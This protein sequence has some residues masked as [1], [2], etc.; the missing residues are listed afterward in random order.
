[1][2]QAIDKKK[3][4][5]NGRWRYVLLG[6]A[7]M[8]VYGTVYSWSIFRIPVEESYGVGTTLSG[9]PY[10]VFLATYAGS[11]MAGGKAIGR[12]SPR[13]ILLAGG[14]LV[15]LGWILSSLSTGIAMLTLTYGLLIGFGVG[16]SY[17]VPIYVITQWFPD[18]RGMTVG[19]VLA[20]FGLSPLFTAPLGSR[21]I[22]AF[23]LERTFLYY[24]LLFGV[25]IFLLAWP[26]KLPAQGASAS[27]TAEG[28]KQEAVPMVRQSS[29]RFAYACFVIGTLIGLAIIG[30][31]NTAGRDLVGLDTGTVAMMMVAFALFNGLGRPLF[32]WITETFGPAAAM[33]ISYGLIGTASLALL[34]AG[35]GT[36]VLY[37]AGFAILWMN[38]GAWL[39]IAPM[40]TMK[41]YGMAAYS[42]NYGIMFTAYG[43]GAVVGVIATG[44]ML[45]LFG[46]YRLL[47]LFMALLAAAG[48]FLSSRVES[49]QPEEDVPEQASLLDNRGV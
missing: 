28:S 26:M 19:L 11:M 39:A 45:D 21:F 4:Q 43:V 6:I 18:K 13:A 32:G 9:L 25:L 22:E 24:G 17:G 5:D 10:M 35:R 20:G 23:G 42:R 15:A 12:F 40:M 27:K 34:F 44:L 7:L 1:M 41:L 38:L 48:F 8:L 14:G 33:R 37:F 36:V 46:D 30:L 16:L 3:T 29:F 47:F 31:T 49:R 2:K